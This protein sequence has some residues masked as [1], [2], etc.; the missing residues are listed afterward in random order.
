M[1]IQLMSACLIA[2]GAAV[3][4]LRWRRISNVFLGGCLAAAIVLI[5]RS[6]P[7]SIA[8]SAAGGALPL[9]LLLPFFRFRMIG[10][11]DIKLLAL[12]GVLL[13]PRTI[14]RCLFWSFAIGA[15]FSVGLMA[16][17]GNAGERFSY[18]IDYTKSI[19]E[20]RQRRPYRK[21]W[22]AR[23]NIHFSVP[24]LMTVLMMTGG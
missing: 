6:G 21:E 3:M 13:G 4:D 16:C 15:V 20:G 18:L 17:C 19:L 1:T 8:S 5:F 24:V 11:G 7:G 22:D 10:A 12:L 23:A 14:L 9:L 2:A